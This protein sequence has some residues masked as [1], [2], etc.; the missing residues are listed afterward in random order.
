MK[1]LKNYNETLFL[2]NMFIALLAVFNA[3]TG[4][5]FLQ[6]DNDIDS[7]TYSKM[8]EIMSL[9]AYG[10]IMLLS[11]VF[12]IVSA[13]Q[14]GKLKYL[15]MIV[16]GITGAIVIGLYASASTIGAANIMLPMRYSLMACG[17]LIIAAVGG[18]GLWRSNRSS[19]P[20]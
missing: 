13:F 5:F 17:Y 19:L 2:A 18:V 11:A 9:D 4:I 3:M 1:V 15:S 8:A 12:L 16:G 14:M 20:S 10:V 6:V 7:P